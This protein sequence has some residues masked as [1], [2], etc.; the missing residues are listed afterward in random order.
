MPTLDTRSTPFVYE[1][2]ELGNSE[3]HSMLEWLSRSYV[4]QVYKYGGTGQKLLED[5]V[6]LFGGSSATTLGSDFDELWEVSAAGRD[7]DDL[8]EVAPVD[9]LSAAGQRRGKAFDE[10]KAEL[11]KS[12]KREVSREIYNK[13]RL[14]WAAVL[15]NDR[16]MELLRTTVSCQK[17]VFWE[18]ANGH[19]RRARW[20]G[21]C[22]D[23]VYDVKTTSSSWDDLAKSF[24][25]Y[26]YFWQAAWY[27]DSAYQIGFG[28][29]RMPFICVQTVPPYECRV[30]VPPVELVDAAGQQIDRTLDQIALRR[31]TGEYLPADYG[32]E[33]E[34]VVPA[35]MWKQ[36]V[37]NEQG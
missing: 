13:L 32:K 11:A 36:E 4:H 9:V 26:G 20:D 1:S 30:W 24:L 3:Y 5:G 28:T 14:M 8:F 29:F 19:K 12:G 22:P 16:A 34:L 7:I 25:N 6:S 31:E 27:Q 23:L 21:E 17:S 2:H 15:A 10:W 37:F 33:A 35:W 18:D